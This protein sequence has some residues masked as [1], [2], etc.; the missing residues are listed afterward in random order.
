MDLDVRRLRVLREVAVRG[1]VV[2]AASSLGFTPSAISQ[3]LAALE[4]EC[5]MKLLERDGRRLR[6]TDAGRLL[7]E[8]TDAVLTALEEAAGALEAS[9]TTVTGEVR[10]SAPASVASALVIPVVA[11][12]AAEVPELRI[13]LTDDGHADGV[14]ELRLGGL[15][16]VVMH[17]YDHARVA[18][19][20]DLLR[21]DLFSEEML[22]AF[23]AD[24]YAT[25]SL[26][27][28][29][30][31]RWATEPAD[32]W[33][34]AAVREACR[35]VGFEPDIRVTSTEF[36]VLL[37]AVA[38]GAVALVPQL[39]VFSA[40]PGVQL[41]PVVGVDTRRHVFLCHRRGSAKRA[42]ITVLLDRLVRAAAELREDLGA[43]AALRRTTASR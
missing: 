11:Q 26:A 13:M 19:T 9:R 16:V 10:V 20:P 34:G 21:V 39:A 37:R 40:P 17:E 30:A 41:L 32:S 5:G 42:S 15:D 25:S 8:R 6:L 18:P 22:I 2:A 35:A 27:D 3:Q 23:P 28:L 29:A 14:R 31:E 7:V 4:R 1:T 24:R 43:E 12:L 36:S 33:C 38:A